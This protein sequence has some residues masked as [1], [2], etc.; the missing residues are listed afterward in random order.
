M[1]S[2]WPM[3]VAASLRRRGSDGLTATPCCT[4]RDMTGT[5]Y[6]GG[7][8]IEPQRAR[9][10]LSSAVGPL[11]NRMRALAGVLPS[12]I[13]IAHTDSPAGQITVGPTT[14]QCPGRPHHGKRQSR[15]P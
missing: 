4:F 3:A 13:W 12:I 2:N 8:A 9:E 5:L 1:S 7:H 14:R 6:R 11:L 15:T 10:K